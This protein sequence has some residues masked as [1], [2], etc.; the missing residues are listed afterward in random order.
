M[1]Q[2]LDE[3]RAAA[4]DCLEAARRRRL[5]SADGAEVDRIGRQN[6]ND[7]GSIADP[8][9]RIQRPLLLARRPQ[10][11]SLDLR[12][13]ALER[14]HAGDHFQRISLRGNRR[15]PPVRIKKSELTHGACSRIMLPKLRL[16]QM[17][18]GR[19]FSRSLWSSR[20]VAWRTHGRARFCGGSRSRS[21]NQGQPGTA[22][23]QCRDR[24]R[25]SGSIAMTDRQRPS[26]AAVCGEPSDVA[27]KMGVPGT[28]Q[29]LAGMAAGKAGTAGWF[30]S[31]MHVHGCAVQMKP[32]WE[33]TTAFERR[34]KRRP[35][36]GHGRW[37]AP[38]GARN[39]R[40]LPGAGFRRTRRPRSVVI[41]SRLSG[42]TI[43]A[44]RRV[45]SLARPLQRH[46]PPAHVGQS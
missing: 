4:A 21:G 7:G 30:S 38:L 33:Q 32:L 5:P 11:R 27:V 18:G 20:A 1:G 15:K 28:R 46:F 26:R 13:E 16:A 40:P 22:C 8:I 14:H 42:P 39:K 37:V 29:R 41:G 6:S 9:I 34:E 35:R 44:C 25:P 2:T 45:Q 19:Y 3:F 36:I 31:L 24:R 12:T 17:R 10:H 23:P 43:G